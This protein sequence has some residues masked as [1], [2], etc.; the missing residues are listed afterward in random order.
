MTMKK[1]FSLLAI[2]V[3]AALSLTSCHLI[4][5]EDMDI[6]YTLSGDWKGDFGM[7]YDYY[8]RHGEYVETFDCYD[9]DIRF[10][11]DYKYATHGRGYQVDYYDFG[12]Y[13]RL[14]HT[15]DW[16]VRNER[17]YLTYHGERE[18]D[19][20][21]RDYRMSSHYFEGYFSTGS[22]KFKLV[23]LNDFYWD[24]HW[25][26]YGYDGYY[27]GWAPTRSGE[28][29]DSIPADLEGGTIRLG[30]RFAK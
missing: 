4:H 8:N 17:I 30:N 28:V 12:P 9:T 3:S 11:P 21:I 27:D 14:Y 6:S 26:D 29:T 1:F 15:F 22:D 16:D 7:Y 24:S 13:K 25:G 5:D 18:Y 19:T 10:V 20:V 23:K 2:M